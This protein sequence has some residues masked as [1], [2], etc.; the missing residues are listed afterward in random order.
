MQIVERC[1]PFGQ[2]VP[3][4]AQGQGRQLNLLGCD[5]GAFCAEGDEIELFLVLLD[6]GG[7]IFVGP[8]VAERLGS[9]AEEAY[10]QSAGF[11]YAGYGCLPELSPGLQPIGTL[12]CLVC[13]VK[14]PVLL[15]FQS[16]Y[17]LQA[18]H[19]VGR[20]GKG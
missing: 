5:R 10:L 12:L 18:F 7:E 11:F 13:F 15:G 9:A 19:A 16:L 6:G 4:V 14:Q 1:M 20:S 8:L 2:C 3:V 17:A